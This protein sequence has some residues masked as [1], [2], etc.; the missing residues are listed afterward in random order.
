MDFSY[1]CLIF[2]SETEPFSCKY[3]IYWFS[4]E[5]Q[6]ASY[7]PTWV[8]SWWPCRKLAWSWLRQS[9]SWQRPGTCCVGRRPTGRGT[10]AR[11]APLTLSSLGKPSTGAAPS[12]WPWTSR[13]AWEPAC[14]SAYRY[15][16]WLLIERPQV[17]S[18]LNVHYSPV[19]PRQ[20]GHF[21]L[22]CSRHPPPRHNPARRSLL[23]SP[24][25]PHRRSPRSPAGSHSLFL[26]L[27]LRRSA[28][29]LETSWRGIRRKAEGEERCRPTVLR[30]L[31][32]EDIQLETKPA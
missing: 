7:N 17:C 6:I 10:V 22:P 3:I 1:Q 8:S 32:K 24:P 2:S 5:K 21:A 19:G 4:Y 23:W 31:P 16:A 11:G 26:F 14:W 13:A 12:P 25:G 15:K 18:W 28:W 9:R 20:T 29:L 30:G 27:Q